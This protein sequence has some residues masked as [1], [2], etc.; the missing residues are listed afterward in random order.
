MSTFR[1]YTDADGETHIET[2]AHALAEY[3]KSRVTPRHE[4]SEP[5]FVGRMVFFHFLPGTAGDWHTAPRR[6]RRPRLTTT[7]PF[8]LALITGLSAA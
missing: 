4:Q 7:D 1:L 6:Q 2:H 8:S 3:A 5:V